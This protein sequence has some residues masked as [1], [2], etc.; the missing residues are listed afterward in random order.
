MAAQQFVDRGI[1]TIEQLRANKDLTPQQI[2]GLRYFDELEQ[3][4][5]REEMD[6]WNVHPTSHVD[7]RQPYKQPSK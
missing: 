2:L 6:I 7:N 4:I 5:P 1:L 3:K